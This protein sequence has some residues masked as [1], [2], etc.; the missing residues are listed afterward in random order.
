MRK[1]IQAKEK[2]YHLENE[3]LECTSENASTPYLG[4]WKKKGNSKGYKTTFKENSRM[5]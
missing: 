3:E 1:I 4:M 5:I 2:R